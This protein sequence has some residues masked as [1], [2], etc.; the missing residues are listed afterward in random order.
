[1]FIQLVLSRTQSA[2]RQ[3]NIEKI[4]KMKFS[5]IHFRIINSTTIT[6]HNNNGT[7]YLIDFCDW[8]YKNGTKSDLSILFTEFVTFT[9]SFIS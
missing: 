2:F 5:V 4:T 3:P 8:Q 6:N 9:C 1:M 7:K